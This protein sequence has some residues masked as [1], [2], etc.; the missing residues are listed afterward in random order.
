MKAHS[1]I[2]TPSYFLFFFSQPLLYLLPLPTAV[3]QLL[4][5]L[6]IAFFIEILD[7]LQTLLLQNTSMDLKLMIGPEGSA[8]SKLVIEL[9]KIDLLDAHEIEGEGAHDARLNGH[10]EDAARDLLLC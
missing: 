9:P 8:S 10:E 5:D 2:F 3:P 6:L 4:G 7:D 1:F